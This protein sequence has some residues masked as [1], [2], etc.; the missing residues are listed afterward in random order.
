MVCV[1]AGKV[2]VLVELGTDDDV[3][4][5]GDL[6]LDMVSALFIALNLS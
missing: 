2:K 4:L 6:V 1:V 3:A 5:A